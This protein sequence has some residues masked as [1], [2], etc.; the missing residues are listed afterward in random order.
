MP[1]FV[2]S[3]VNLSHEAWMTRSGFFFAV[4][5]RE[6]SKFSRFNLLQSSRHEGGDCGHLT[7]FFG[8]FL[9]RG[10]VASA[11]SRGASRADFYGRGIIGLSGGEWTNASSRRQIYIQY[12]IFKSAASLRVRACAC[13]L[14]WSN[15]ERSASIFSAGAAH[16][17]D[18]DRLQARVCRS[19]DALPLFQPFG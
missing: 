1:G 6:H 4:I 18:D 11:M 2:F 5:N 13:S 16:D 19:P 7:D 12:D 10:A 3:G 14:K 9:D 8:L 15:E 17:G